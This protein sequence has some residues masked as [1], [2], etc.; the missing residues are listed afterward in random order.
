MHVPKDVIKC[1]VRIHFFDVLL[2]YLEKGRLIVL[3][4]M[5]PYH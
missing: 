5:W 2:F 4:L 3:H 1:K